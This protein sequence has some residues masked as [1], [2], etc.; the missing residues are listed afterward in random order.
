V[1]LRGDTKRVVWEWFR[2]FRQ[3]RW[4]TI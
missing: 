1:L 3:P 2:R 4:T